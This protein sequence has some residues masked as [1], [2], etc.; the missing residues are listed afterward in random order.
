MLCFQS[1]QRLRPYRALNFFSSWVYTHF[2][3]TGL[4]YRRLIELRMTSAAL[5]S[6]VCERPLAFRA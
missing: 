5:P 1:P 6:D 4:F 3:P 2:V